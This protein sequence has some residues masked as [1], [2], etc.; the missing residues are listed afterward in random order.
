M[1]NLR[2]QV[3]LVLLL[4][5]GLAAPVRRAGAAPNTPER[6]DRAQTAEVTSTAARGVMSSE[7]EVRGTNTTPCFVENFTFP[8]IELDQSAKSPKYMRIGYTAD[9]NCNLLEAS[10]T[11]LSYVPDSVDEVDGRLGPV[12]SA[13]SL[14]GDALLA[15]T[16][17]HV[18]I[19]QND[20]CG[21]TT[22]S[23]RTDQPWAWTATTAAIASG[24]KTQPGLCCY[25]WYL[26][27]GPTMRNGAYS[28]THVY[29][30]GTAGYICHDSQ[31]APFCTGSTWQYPMTFNT[32]LHMYSAGAANSSGTGYVGAII[33]YG[34]IWIEF[35]IN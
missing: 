11:T 22:I 1:K 35:W 10:R 30:T 2:L 4:L 5:I 3:L 26:T 13:D 21:I 33:P 12:T 29:A 16:T 32:S 34:S 15:T 7:P 18:K 27:A 28:L 20:C 31:P 25:W 9:E 23:L 17:A 14:S 19:Y 24:G 8:A 6:S